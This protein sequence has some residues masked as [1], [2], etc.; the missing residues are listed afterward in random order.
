MG[1]FILDE[2]EMQRR[3]AAGERGLTTAFVKAI[4]AARRLDPNA[5]TFAAEVG[6]ALGEAT[7]ASTAATYAAS[8]AATSAFIGNALE[9]NI[10]FNVQHERAIAAQRA[11]NLRF[12]N[13]FTTSQRQATQAALV[14]GV[15]RGLNPVAQARAFRDSIGLTGKQELA[16]QRYRA[17]LEGAHRG[18][19]DALSR[20]LRDKRGDRAVARAARDGQPLTQ[21][22]INSMVQRYQRRYVAY[23]AQT[24]ARTES[25]RA[26]NAANREAWLQA[27][28]DPDVPIAN[29]EVQR[30]W[31]TAGDERVRAPHA[32]AHGQK[33]V[34]VDTP[35]IVA[36]EALLYPGHEA[37]SAANVV[38]CRC[39]EITTLTA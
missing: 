31:F 20:Q 3:Y 8:G 34:G 13:A 11:N 39:A 18:S 22:Q 30:E 19:A 21:T 26:V 9:L 27:V 7:A 2:V 23:R 35:F 15:Q 24:I 37:G 25:L 17:A 28:Q 16:V 36:G 32:D 4:K 33:V 38:L 10:D 1:K 29:S 12:V 14:D 5:T 6:A